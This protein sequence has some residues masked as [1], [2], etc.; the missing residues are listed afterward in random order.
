MTM[1]RNDGMTCRGPGLRD[2]CHGH[3]DA[4]AHEERAHEAHREREDGEQQR[5][6]S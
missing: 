2:E 3:R 4:R 5:S 6:S 1:M